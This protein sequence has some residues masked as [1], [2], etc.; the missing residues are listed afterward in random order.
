M[1]KEEKKAPAPQKQ[2]QQPK[3]QGG[4]E[5]A[6]ACKAESCKKKPEKFGFCLE[7]YEM[8]MA[9]VLRGDGAKPIDYEE[10]LALFLKQKQSQKRAA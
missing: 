2:Q 3:A 5:V 1:A 8:Y 9:G 6:S 7:H 10:K 4:P